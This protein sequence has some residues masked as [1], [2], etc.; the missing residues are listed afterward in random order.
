MVASAGKLAF[1]SSFFKVAMSKLFAASASVFFTPSRPPTSIGS[2]TNSDRDFH[3][4]PP[5]ELRL[6][7]PQA[8]P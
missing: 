2:R 7:E 3:A 8:M 4:A 5:R 1:L 6:G